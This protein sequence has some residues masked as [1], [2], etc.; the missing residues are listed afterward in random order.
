MPGVLDGIT[1]FFYVLTGRA[2]LW[3]RHGKS[4]EVTDLRPT[5]A[6]SIPAGTFVQHRTDDL[7]SSS[8]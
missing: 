6:V 3:R 5:R 4:V 2:E 8:W 1:E 7:R